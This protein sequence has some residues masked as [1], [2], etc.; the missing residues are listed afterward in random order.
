MLRGLYTAAAGMSA[1]MDRQQTITNNLAN[2]NTPGFKQDLTALHSFPNLLLQQMGGQDSGASIG[3]LST[4]VYA[5]E[6][7]TDFS[8]GT[9]KTTNQPTDIALVGQSLPVNPT[10]KQPEGALFFTVKQPDGQI[11]YTRNGSFS[12]DGL[13]RLATA[14]GNLVLDQKGQPIT[15]QSNDFTVESDGSIVQN[16][17]KTATI[18]M[19]Y[20][21][22]PNQQLEKDGEGLYKSSKAVN[23]PM[24]QTT[25]GVSFQLKQ[26]SLETSNVQLDQSMTDLMMAYRSFQANQQVL[27]A[28]DSTLDLAANKVGAVE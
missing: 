18:G 21:T 10:T 20:S 5:Q 23:L 14:E 16:G 22:N 27:K 25:P 2:V 19:A 11:R 6:N 24:A 3:G 28:Y 12:I 9:P 1:Q 13:N 7:M 4:G 15:L 8:I 26:G 17:S